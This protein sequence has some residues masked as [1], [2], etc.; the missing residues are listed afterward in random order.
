[1]TSPLESALATQIYKGMKNLFLDATLTRDVA[2][3]ITDPADP[4]APTATPYAC[5]AI[6]ET[7]SD[8]FR[9][10]GM[11]DAKDRKVLILAD[12]LTVQPV[13]N[14]RVTISGITFTVMEVGTDPATAVWEC[15]GRM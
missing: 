9:Q 8:Y 14:D 2:G 12:S 13:P 6:V 15:K 5:K 3:T 11:V 1:M 7:Y 10:N 4:P